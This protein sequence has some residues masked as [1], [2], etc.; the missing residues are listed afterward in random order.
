VEYRIL[1]RLE[2]AHRDEPVALGTAKQQALLGMLL[3]HPNEVVASDR[4]IDE[5]WGARPPP[6]ATKIVQTYVSQLRKTLGREAIETCPPGY[7]LRVDEAAIDA[8]RFHRLTTEGRRAAAHGDH[9]RADRRYGEALALWRGPPLTGLVFESFA[10]NEL[11]RLE[12][13]RL[14]T[15]LERIDCELALGRHVE[16]VPELELLVKQHPLQERLRAQ[17][18]LA[19]YR[20]D[21]QAEALALYQDTRRVLVDELGLEPSRKLQE[22]ERAI[23]T[24][25]DTLNEPSRIAADT[26]EGTLVSGD[27]A[28]S[29]RPR[30]PRPLVIAGGGVVALMA[31]LGGVLLATGPQRGPNSRTR[32]DLAS[33]FGLPGRVHAPRYRV[34][35]VERLTS[36]AAG[37]HPRL[38][39]VAD[40]DS[41]VGNVED[42]PAQRATGE[43]VFRLDVRQMNRAS[44]TAS[45]VGTQDLLVAAEG[46]QIGYAAFG[47]GPP[48]VQ[49]PLIKRGV[50]IDRETAEPVVH[51]SIGVPP[52]FAPVLGARYPMT[53]RV[54]TRQLVL[55]LNTQRLVSAFHSKRGQD[56]AF[57][58][59]GL[60][61][62]GEY[63]GSR[64]RSNSAFF[65][66][67][68]ERKTLLGAS[69]SAR[70]CMDAAC[71]NLGTAATD[72]IRFMLP[73]AVTVR[74][75]AHVL[76]GRRARFSGTGPPGDSIALAYEVM[77]RTGPLCT[78]LS[79]PD[80]L[81]APRYAPFWDKLDAPTTTVTADGNWS[82]T[83]A[84]RPVV[85]PYL[86]HAATGR[87]VAVD[88]VGTA[89]GG[90]A[91]GGPFSIFAAAGADTEVALPTPRLAARQR[92]K[93][94]AV[95][96]VVP[97]GDSLVRLQLRVGGNPIAAGSLDDAG[98]F[99]TTLPLPRRRE[100]LEARATVDGATS[101]R[102][103]LDVGRLA[104]TARPNSDVR[105]PG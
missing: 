26:L 105:L 52:A 37:A 29:R 101:S 68:P 44:K 97:G 63:S 79:V 69:V 42:Q 81:C 90:N 100:T 22:L 84:L 30:L 9:E 48:T 62:F 95:S 89:F 14:D 20:S 6:T 78:P 43:L 91:N 60:Y 34:A 47:P 88:Y 85:A 56:I 51:V 82:L 35:L 25:D 23:L 16:L 27:P 32:T 98:K 31:V 2:V 50:T 55:T 66:T 18:M 86:S 5:L 49:N 64:G 12:Q 7:L 87:Y 72:S 33:L 3:L 41:G 46:T 59:V 96:V 1:G 61:F 11:A 73:K 45:A 99:S 40:I 74:V 92:G 28:A 19:L 57:N 67:N 93:R 36:G 53:I 71:A 17:L 65:A 104:D 8:H 70:P 75:P 15:Q 54:G 39:L 4:L 58:S 77:P 102:A 94:L 83:T 103:S 13:E 24:H 21:R 10:R 76:Y 38:G 80:M